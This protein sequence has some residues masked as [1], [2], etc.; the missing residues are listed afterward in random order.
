M[1][2]QVATTRVLPFRHHMGRHQQL[3]A[4][5]SPVIGSPT[6]P[7]P[8][9]LLL[10]LLVLLVVVLSVLRARHHQLRHSVTRARR[11][12]PPHSPPVQLLYNHFKSC[13][14]SSHTHSA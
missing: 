6:P 13:T 9:V 3:R 5:P 11:T 12:S 1:L 8:E 7:G 4:L 2:V 14:Y 10:V